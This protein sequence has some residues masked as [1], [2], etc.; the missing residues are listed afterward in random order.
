MLL[1]GCGGN[2]EEALSIYMFGDVPRDQEDSIRALIEDELGKLGEE[3]HI[4]IE[5][6]QHERILVILAANEG[7]VYFINEQQ[8]QVF[9]DP[10]GLT[11]LDDRFE[12]ANIE[13]SE[14]YTVVNEATGD[15][16]LLALPINEDTYF[17]D[18]LQIN[19]ANDMVAFVDKR[20]EQIELSKDIL[21]VLYEGRP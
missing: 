2:D 12:A 5:S 19:L 14:A 6:A 9:F 8:A 17:I 3:L 13:G 21:K 20:S 4:S 18:E 1:A 11:P 15:E 7:D 10:V 16:E